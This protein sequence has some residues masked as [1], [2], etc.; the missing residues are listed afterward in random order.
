M[1]G[2]HREWAAY[3]TPILAYAYNS[4]ESVTKQKKIALSK[5]VD[6]GNRE[7]FY[8]LHFFFKTEKAAFPTMQSK[9]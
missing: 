7:P 9:P 3:A 5:S 2:Q 8:I 4:K 6:V 1:Q